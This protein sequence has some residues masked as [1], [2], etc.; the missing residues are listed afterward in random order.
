MKALKILLSIIVILIIIIVVGGF[1]L[2]KTYSVNRSIVINA[3]DSVIYK[4]IADFSEFTK[5][6]PWSKMEPSA[7]ITI[8]GPASQP[9]HL[10]EWKGKQTG[11]GSMKIAAVKPYSQVNID[12]NFLKPFKSSAITTFD[13]QPEGKEQKVTWTMSGE[14]NLVSKWMCVFVSMDKMI[15]KDFE[16]GLKSLKEQSETAH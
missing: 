14:Q 6:N 8:S 1:F 5:W 2:P 11:E 15:G 9:G 3:P 7:K 16:N 10:Y 12:L 4:N 13:I